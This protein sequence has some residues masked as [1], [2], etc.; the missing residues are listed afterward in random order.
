MSKDKIK[1]IKESLITERPGHCSTGCTEIGALTRRVSARVCCDH[2]KGE[3][4]RRVRKNSEYSCDSCRII[5]FY[6]TLSVQWPILR[7]ICA[8]VSKLA[9]QSENKI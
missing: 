6:S 1:E 7:L 8:D 4:R 3:E 5:G 2:E 9:S